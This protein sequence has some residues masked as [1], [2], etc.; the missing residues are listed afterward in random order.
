MRAAIICATYRSGYGYQENHWAE[1]LCRQGTQVRVFNAGKC[2]RVYSEKVGAVSCEVHT[3][4]ALRGPSASFLVSGLAH[5]VSKF[6][7]NLLLWFAPEQFFGTSLLKDGVL[8]HRS[9]SYAFFGLNRGQHEFGCRFGEQNLHGIVK[10]LGW[11][12][13]RG[14]YTK[15]VCRKV[16]Y[17]VCTVP[18]TKDILLGLFRDNEREQIETKCRALPLGFS[19]QSYY[20]DER[21]RAN[22]RR[23]M[24][25]PQDA[26]VVCMSCRFGAAH[27]ER[28]NTCVLQGI[29][30]ALADCEDAH[31][32]L[33]GF[34]DSMVS[35]RLRALCDRS[36]VADRVHLRPFAVQEE[37]NRVY[38]AADIAVFPNASISCQAALG[39][40]AWVALS[41]NG[42][43]D[44]LVRNAQRHV[45]VRTD[46]ADA[47]RRSLLE[48]T[49]RIAGM[50]AQQRLEQRC[51]NARD[52]QWLSYQ[53]LAQELLG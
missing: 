32:L 5:R 46:S 2:G 30:A 8:L 36:A 28:R 49:C 19:Q 23:E 20:W 6:Q 21:L 12:I 44:H 10:T 33:V 24:G 29:L 17:V 25:I 52:S 27:K 7:P 34:D 42:T 4:K 53:Q 43:M 40:G 18:E 14:S 47:V 45:H 3:L 13:L 11:R 38:N 9:R 39:T 16:G 26:V 22:G 35:K 41:D 31:A 1:E 51:Q 50:P 15:W 37:L 48:L